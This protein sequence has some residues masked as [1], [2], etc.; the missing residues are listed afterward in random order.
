MSE[1]RDVQFTVAPHPLRVERDVRF[2][3]E[4]QTIREM[5]EGAGVDPALRAYAVVFIG[6]QVVPEEWWGRVRP[7]AGAHVE[8]R[9]VPTGG[10]GGKN[11]LRIILTLVVV[12]ASAF[13]GPALGASIFGVSA[14]TAVIGSVTAGA[15]GKALI[16]LAGFVLTSVLI[17][18]RPPKLPS[19]SGQ[20]NT[21]SPT[22]F[23]QGARNDVRPFAP[24]P[25]VL[26]RHRMSPP[27]AAQPYTEVVGDNQYVRLLFVWGAAPL[28]IDVSSFRIG[29]T[30]LSSFEGVQIQHSSD[31]S[32][33]SLFSNNIQQEDLSIFLEQATS[34]ETRT[35]ERD[36]DE[37]S[38][39]VT[40]P[41]GL[42]HFNDEGARSTRTATME[43]EYRRV[44]TGTWLKPVYSATTVPPQWIVS[45]VI[46]MTHNRTAAVRHGFR[47]P[48]SPRGQY[49][50]RVRRVSADTTSSL[51][52]DKFYWTA[53]RTIINEDPV[54]SPVPL[55]KT[56]IRIK[57]TDQLNGVVNTFSGIVTSIGPVWNGS[58]WTNAQTRNPAGLARLVLQG[59]MNA[60]PVP[61]SRLDLP[62][63][64]AFH[65]FCANQ[66]F[67]FNMV[68]DFAST[69]WETLVDVCAAGRGMPTIVD[70]KWSIIIDQP[71]SV[72]VSHITPRNS[73]DFMIEKPFVTPPHAW[74]IRFP[75]ELQDY[76]Q[77]ERR[78][79]F[80]GYSEGTATRFESIE[81]PGI[82]H[83]DQVQRHGRYRARSALQQQE[84]WS[85]SQDMEFLV[86][87]RGDRV[88]VTHDVLL[89][90]LA[91]GRIKD[92]V[93]NGS[94][95]ITVLVFDEPVDMN[96]SES[97]GVV[98]RTIAGG[99]IF[100]QVNAIDGEGIT[101]VAL[102]TAIPA[103]GGEP[104]VARGELFSF[105]LHGLERDDAQVVSIQPDA[106]F[107][108]RV[109]C[110][111]YRSVIYDVDAEEI[112]EFDSKLTPLVPVPTPKIRGVVTNETVLTLGPGESLQTR[113]A[114]DFDPID[115]N[116]LDAPQLRVQG[117]PSGTNGPF[118]NMAVDETSESRVIVRGVQDGQTWDLRLRFEIAG[119]IP[120]AWAYTYNN[121]VVGKS[122]PPDKLQNLTISTF[123][124]Q[125]FLRWDPPTTLDV[126]FGGYVLFR[127]SP[128]FTGATWGSSTSIGRAARARTLL[129]TLPLKPGTY[130]ARVVDS[131]GRYSTEVTSVTTKQASV[132]TFAS[133]ASI[134]EHSTFPGTKTD[135]IVDG[136]VLQIDDDGSG[137]VLPSG[138]YDFTNTLDLT[139]VSR[140]RVTSHVEASV[141]N[142]ADTIDSRTDPIDLWDDFD[143]LNSG[144][145]D[146]LVYVRHTD[147]DPGGT[148]EWSAWELLDSMELEARA[149]QFYAELISNDPAFNVLV[150][151]LGVEV[152]ELA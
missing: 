117:R 69:V 27:Y 42:V 102:L 47:W 19:L 131:V 78:V 10:G 110:V 18:S 48:V 136:L 144:A 2:C 52:V 30:P 121:L 104:A 83:P 21:D 53:L 145:G 149:F 66:G 97:Y 138:R 5:I 12:A 13:L 4:G 6:G 75:N 122:T 87:R 74:R 90:G 118:Y 38:V 25:A 62:S 1:R 14:S 22:L 133:V 123:G 105:G 100:R 139:T 80:D 17:P 37:I 41:N 76:R 89:V 88:T 73:F 20:A 35:T 33:L 116:R 98:L 49:E 64:Q 101:A 81:L 61:D 57:A 55:E 51:I 148:P 109:T 46:S 107:R 68:R 11:P 36:A 106:D 43:I 115:D 59:P 111:P 45:D 108:A 71:Q 152:E 129:A 103:I 86:Y 85:F 132:H 84:R 72:P 95:D 77:D 134:A 50:V 54:Q 44:G 127:H 143:G 82:T 92:F 26:G 126:E 128:A 8:L 65:V 3:P 135:V 113:I 150:T 94:N 91:S 99:I 137:M 39:D 23:I 28:G 56:A 141:A 124:G 34:W 140:V 70:G 40:F 119:R 96:S 7:R 31:G 58:T 29:E 125:A 112:P 67:Q 32:P 93:V 142:V 16:G 9:V 120:G 114:V 147:D 15:I 151:E 130:L 79:Y 63:F 24:V 60:D 146:V